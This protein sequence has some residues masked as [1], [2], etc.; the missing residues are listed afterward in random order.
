MFDLLLS[1]LCL[2]VKQPLTLP[3]FSMELQGERDIV[4]KEVEEFKQNTN[5]YMSEM[6]KKINEGKNQ[7]DALTKEVGVNH[8]HDA[9]TRYRCVIAKK[10]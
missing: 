2:Y 5:K 4:Q 3:L 6:N 8:Q 1:F 10:T 9:V 7:H